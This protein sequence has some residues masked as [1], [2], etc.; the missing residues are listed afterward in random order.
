MAKP[1][2]DANVT[3]WLRQ[4]LQEAH[5][6]LLRGMLTTIAEELMGAEAQALCGAEYGERTSERHNSRNE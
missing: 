2:M 4:R 3:A 6:D 5:P 1:N